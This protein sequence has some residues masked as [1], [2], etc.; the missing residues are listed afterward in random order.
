KITLIL[1]CTL[2]KGH[3][4]KVRK[5]PED[6]DITCFIPIISISKAHS[7]KNPAYPI[8]IEKLEKEKRCLQASKRGNL[9]I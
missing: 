5:H 9:N 2:C 3:F 7:S 4:E 8:T 1:I 6:D